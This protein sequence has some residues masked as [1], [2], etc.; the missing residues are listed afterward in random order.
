MP[1]IQGLISGEP[2]TDSGKLYSYS[3]LARTFAHLGC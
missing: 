2:W 1:L 3:M